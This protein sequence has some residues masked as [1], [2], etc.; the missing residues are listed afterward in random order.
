MCFPLRAKPQVRATGLA[1]MAAEGLPQRARKAIPYL[2][3]AHAGLDSRRAVPEM[4]NSLLIYKG[5][6]GGF[7][8]LLQAARSHWADFSQELA[9]ALRDV[10]SPRSRCVARRS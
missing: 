5:A 4:A 9:V 8:F 7:R 6:Q 1:G 3:T 10:S 2:D